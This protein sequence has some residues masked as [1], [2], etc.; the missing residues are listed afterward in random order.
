[1]SDTG[2]LPPSTDELT[3]RATNG[4]VAEFPTLRVTPGSTAD[5]EARARARL[6]VDQHQALAQLGRNVTPA[7]ANEAGLEQWAT[8]LDEPRKGASKVRGTLALEV[9]G[10][11]G[12]SLGIGFVLDHGSG[13]QYQNTTGA[14]IGPALPGSLLGVAL[15]DVES[16]DTGEQTRLLAGEPLT[17][18]S[19]PVDI[20]QSARLTKSLTDG[21]ADEEAIGAWR[22]RLTLILRDKRVEGTVTG[23]TLAASAQPDVDRVFLYRRKPT[24]G[25]ISV[26]AFKEGSGTA[27]LQSP[28]ERETLA[29][30]MDRIINDTVIPL[31]PIARVVHVDVV[32]TLFPTENRAF[33]ANL[34]V[35]TWDPGSATLTVNEVLDTDV[36]VGDLL[37]IESALP[38]TTGATGK[39]VAVAAITGVSSMV[40]VSVDGEQPVLDFTPAAADVVYPSSPAMFEAWNAIRFGSTSCATLPGLEQLGPANPEF[41]YGSWLSDMRTAGISQ[42]ARTPSGIDDAVATLSTA[43]DIELSV[44]FPF[45]DDDQV[46]VLLAG[47][48]VVW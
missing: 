8:A 14:T 5:A 41:K 24:A 32:V 16:I 28:S 9:N 37:T 36:G 11:P 40:L 45:P 17:F 15:V 13:L 47:Q 43:N 6:A 39:P 20:S 35:A 44:E 46:E 7:T 21:G 26:M 34:T 31:E 27:K 29:E 10:T 33:S 1:M 30:E 2:Y 19:P 42:L 25:S 38:D 22:D 48:V 3:D 18:V 4:F 23:Y 12:A